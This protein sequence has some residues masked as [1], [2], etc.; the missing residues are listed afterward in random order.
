MSF[1]A[2]ALF[3]PS[4]VALAR[5]F[6]QRLP[7]AEQKAAVLGGG[8]IGILAMQWLRILGAMEVSVFDI[9]DERLTLHSGWAQIRPITRWRRNLKI[10]S[11]RFWKRAVLITSLRRLVSQ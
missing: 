4:T 10:R 9:A 2:G 11:A 5:H 1:E 6:P 7:A 8:N 3:E